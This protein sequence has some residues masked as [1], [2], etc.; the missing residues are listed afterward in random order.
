MVVWFTPG[1]LPSWLACSAEPRGLAGE[2][3]F[4]DEAALQNEAA[5]QNEEERR[6]I[7]PALALSLFRRWSVWITRDMNIRG[8]I[9]AS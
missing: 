5:F 4:Q 8:T 7:G 1:R 2:A 3:A 6:P 9:N